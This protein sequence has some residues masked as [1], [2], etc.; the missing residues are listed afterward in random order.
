MAEAIQ[1]SVPLPHSIDSRI[2]LHL[3]ARSKYV[4][5]LVTTAGAEEVGIATP[6]GSFV[7]ALPD[8]FNP[9][10]PL[11]TPLFTVE[12]TIEFTTRLA[13]LLARKTGL[14]AYVGNSLSLASTGLGGTVEEEMDA[15]K[16]VVETLVPLLDNIINSG[17]SLPNGPESSS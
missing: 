9:N 16:A 17:H 8:R 12:P 1:V 7:Y 11:S 15:F 14:P 3:T 6:L 13:K 5:L 10:Q 4:M 2:Y